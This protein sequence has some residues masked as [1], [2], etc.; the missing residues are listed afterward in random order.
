MLDYKHRRRRDALE[1]MMM[2]VII[3]TTATTIILIFISECRFHV[4]HTVLTM[5]RTQIV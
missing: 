1:G 4:P 3:L 2:F 5:T